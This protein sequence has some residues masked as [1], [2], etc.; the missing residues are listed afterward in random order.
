MKRLT[1]ALCTALLVSLALASIA[2]AQDGPQFR[3]GFKALSEL[4]PNVA[5]QPLE[6]EHYN[7]ENGD[8][9]QQHHHGP[10]GVAEGRQLDGLH[11]R[12][13]HLDQR[14][15]GAPEP[16]QRGALR[17]GDPGA[18]RRGGKCLTWRAIRPRL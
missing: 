2:A 8:S 1:L 7:A 18:E 9:L 14:P 4:I 12:V 10:D 13:H 5:G 11:R 6:N 17:L 15:G 16:A 3:F